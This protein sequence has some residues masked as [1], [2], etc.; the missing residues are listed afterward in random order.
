MSNSNSYHDGLS[1]CVHLDPALST[2]AP[3]EIHLFAYLSCLLALY[4]KQPVA[5]WGYD[6]GAVEGGYPYSP[7]LDQSI[8]DLV[9]KGYLHR[10][11]DTFLHVTPTGREEA[12]WL[13]SMTAG[14]SREVYIAGACDSVL[15]LPL[16]MIRDALNQSTDLR[17]A[18]ISNHARHLPSDGGTQVF[19]DHFDV[20]SQA[21][22]IDVQDLMIPAVIWLQFLATIQ[23][24]TPDSHVTA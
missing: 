23:T 15:S 17:S 21:V 1:I 24:Q 14:S 16:G 22:G 9:E 6:F 11:T 5:N 18:R 20:L 3:S 7:S 13:Q 19:H 2:I 12:A 8:T 10:D 4:R